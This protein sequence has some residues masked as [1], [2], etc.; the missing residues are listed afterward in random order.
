MICGRRE[1]TQPVQLIMHSAA[2]G[3]CLGDKP[4][5]SWTI[6]LCSEHRWQVDMVG[7]RAFWRRQTINPFVIALALWRASPDITIMERILAEHR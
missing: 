4:H 6:P 3:K 5:G 1:T 7:E 2:Y